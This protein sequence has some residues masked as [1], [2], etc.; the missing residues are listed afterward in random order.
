[1]V[2]SLPA[3]RGYTKDRRLIL[4]SRRSA[5]EGNSNHASIL[6]WEIPWIEAPGG[7]QSTGARGVGHN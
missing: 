1:M 5:G 3:N 4:G 7:L 6:A 2:K